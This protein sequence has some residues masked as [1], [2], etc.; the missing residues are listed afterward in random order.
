MIEGYTTPFLIFFF[1][2]FCNPFLN[3]KPNQP[4]D[5]ETEK[6]FPAE[7]S[8]KP[9]IRKRKNFYIWI[10]LTTFKMNAL[11]VK[12][13]RNMVRLLY[14]LFF[15]CKFFRKTVRSQICL[16]SGLKLGILKKAIIDILIKLAV[17]TGPWYLSFWNYF[18]QFNKF[19]LI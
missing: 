9:K 1:L 10:L 16:C 6:S 12:S 18:F 14:L 5:R 4:T 17:V 3:H 13:I 15:L 11:M 19:F 2:Q 7:I 8:I